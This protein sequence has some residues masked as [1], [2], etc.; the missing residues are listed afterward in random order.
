MR[1]RRRQPPSGSLDWTRRGGEGPGAARLR[2][3]PLLAP[4]CPP[5]PSRDSPLASAS[6]PESE[7]A[8]AHGPPPPGPP[9]ASRRL[10]AS[11]GAPGLTLPSSQAPSLAPL[12]PG[13]KRL[14]LVIPTNSLQPHHA[15]HVSIRTHATH[16]H[17][18]H[19]QDNTFRSPQPMCPLGRASSPGSHALPWRFPQVPTRHRVGEQPGPAAGV[20]AQRVEQGPD[21]VLTPAVQSGCWPLCSSW[22]LSPQGPASQPPPAPLKTCLRV[23]AAVWTPARRTKSWGHEAEL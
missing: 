16:T 11:P 20:R 18:E 2:L 4:Q 3:R 22:E 7:Q 5:H 1:C 14:I 15:L 23:V 21:G 8:S 10:S 12:P 17:T 19:T 13:D 6:P 9:S